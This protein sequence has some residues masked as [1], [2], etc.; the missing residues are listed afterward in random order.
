MYE[1][2]V[3]ENLFSCL[4]LVH[5]FWQRIGS[6]IWSDDVACYDAYDQGFVE[7]KALWNDQSITCLGI[8]L[9]IA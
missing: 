1:C 4:T 3:A 6:M 5:I 7:K 8:A 2:L 9:C